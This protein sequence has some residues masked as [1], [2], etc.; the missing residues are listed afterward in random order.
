[1]WAT[2]S[3]TSQ[4]GHPV[5]RCHS[6]LFRSASTERWEVHVCSPVEHA[7]HRGIHSADASC[8]ARCRLL[9][10]PGLRVAY[11]SAGHLAVFV[12]SRRRGTAKPA[13]G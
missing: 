1:M 5:G 3:W 13:P 9:A 8:A 10:Q 7:R 11:D 6:R 2:L 4:P 12:A